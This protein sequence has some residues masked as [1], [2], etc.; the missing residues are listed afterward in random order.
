MNRLCSNVV[1]AVAGGVAVMAWLACAHR[2]SQGGGLD[3]P[4]RGP[5]S[6]TRWEGEGGAVP[7]IEEGKITPI[8]DF[9]G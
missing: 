5:Q 4:L 6:L 9:P 7:D 3:T 2:R 1:A 8:R